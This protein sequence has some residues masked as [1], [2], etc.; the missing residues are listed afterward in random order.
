M[1]ERGVSSLCFYI[2]WRGKPLEKEMD[3]EKS[4][5]LLDFSPNLQEYKRTLPRRKKQR[6][7][8]ECCGLSSTSWVFLVLALLQGR[9][10]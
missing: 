10:V 1:L 4:S 3:E 5:N 2:T 6:S 7:K 9:Y 8:D